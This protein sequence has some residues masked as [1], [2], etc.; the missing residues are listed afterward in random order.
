MELEYE[1]SKFVSL[2]KAKKRK[3]EIRKISKIDYVPSQSFSDVNIWNF[4]EKQDIVEK[5]FHRGY[6]NR[7]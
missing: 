3:K 7:L 2:D 4:Q 5:K 6:R 1:A